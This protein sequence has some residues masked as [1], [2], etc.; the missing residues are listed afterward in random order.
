[1]K[2]IL[3]PCVRFFTIAVFGAGSFLATSSEILAAK[4]NSQKLD[5]TYDVQATPCLLA[6]DEHVAEDVA[7]SVR[8]SLEKEFGAKCR[9]V[10]APLQNPFTHGNEPMW[11]ATDSK[12][13]FGLWLSRSIDGRELLVRGL[14]FVS[15]LQFGMNKATTH[16]LTSDSAQEAFVLLAG[17][18]IKQYPYIGVSTGRKFVAWNMGLSNSA[19][20][21]RSVGVEFL[22]AAD[23]IR[24]P[25]LPIRIDDGSSSQTIGKGVFR[26]NRILLAKTN[27]KEFESALDGDKKLWLK[28]THE[29]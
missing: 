25:F 17:V 15:R 29:R 14:D 12:I 18:V 22:L 27:S 10:E 13:I 2:K 16:N 24:H 7:S 4:N 6:H 11:A 20:A 3:S 28:R 21:D 23:P 26:Q 5:L 9:L 8:E 1:M 19:N